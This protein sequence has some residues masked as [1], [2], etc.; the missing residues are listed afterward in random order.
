MWT[1]PLLE[2]A[3]G[4]FDLA[5]LQPFW[6]APESAGGLTLAGLWVAEMAAELV[7]V[8]LLTRY[9]S[10]LY[11]ALDRFL[12]EPLLIWPTEWVLAKLTSLYAG[13]LRWS[14]RL[15]GGVLALGVGL[16]AVTVLFLAF[17]VL[18]MELVPSED[19]SRFVVHVICPVGS[20]I[21]QV[22]ELLQECE[23]TLAGRDDVAGLLTTVATEPGQLMNEADI[24]VHLT[25]QS[26]RPLKQQRIIQEVRRDLQAIH[27][28][29]VVVRDQSTEGFTAQRGDP[30]DFAIQGDWKELP[31]H[32]SA[33]TR[34]MAQS[35]AVH[36]ID[37]DYRPGMP[38]VQIRPDREKLAM[39]GIPVG[40][41]ADTLS[42]L[43]GGQRVGK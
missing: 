37:S 39:V 18:G 26:Q 21:D 14:L 11:W 4:A 25:P 30:V 3:D 23:S 40:R 12:L 15:W 1:W 24:F 32:A 10:I 38:E 6:P 9:A 42:L 31:N 19:Q 35:G 33:I 8:V 17:N 29:R 5:G 28:V 2:L 36:D 16:I 13:L 41:L 7:L 27:D 22:D 43:V 34:A 20:S